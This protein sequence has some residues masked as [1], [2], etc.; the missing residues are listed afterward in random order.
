METFEPSSGFTASV[1]R[2]IAESEEKRGLDHW[3]RSRAVRFAVTSAGLLVGV[4]NL[5][6]LCLVFFA[7][8]LCQ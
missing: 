8:G 7:P 1:M 5:A 2:R 6:R 4:A 3:L